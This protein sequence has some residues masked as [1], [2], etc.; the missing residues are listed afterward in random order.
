MAFGLAGM[1]LHREAWREHMIVYALFV[2]FAAVTG[3]FFGHTSHRSY[4]DVYWIVFAAGLLSG[5][6]SREASSA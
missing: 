5:W 1:F 4:L 2:S 6:F 3:V